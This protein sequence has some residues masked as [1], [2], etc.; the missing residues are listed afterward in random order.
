MAPG[1]EKFLM[2]TAQHGKAEVELGRLASE[3]GSAPAAG[4]GGTALA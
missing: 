2:K 1:D 3:K 4:R